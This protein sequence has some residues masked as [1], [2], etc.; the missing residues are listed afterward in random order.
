MHLILLLVEVHRTQKKEKEN[1]FQTQTSYRI[2][3]M[4]GLETCVIRTDT[5]I[6]VFQMK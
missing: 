3:M 1:Y 6:K 4:K 2:L 5:N